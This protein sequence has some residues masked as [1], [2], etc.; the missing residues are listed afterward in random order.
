MAQKKS[1]ANAIA[2]D[3]AGNAYL[4]GTTKSGASFPSAQPLQN[5]V[6][7]NQ[8]SFYLKL[9]ATG[10]LQYAGLIGGNKND[11]GTGIALDTSGN[12]Y[13]TGYTDSA[14]D[15]PLAS[16]WQPVYGG[17]AWD[18][19]LVAITPAGDQLLYSSYFGGEKND[20]AQDI[21]VDSDGTVYL[22]GY[23][24]SPVD[25]PLMQAWQSIFGGSEDA[26]VAR[27]DNT[28]QLEYATYFGGKEKDAG[29]AIALDSYGGITI[30]G[31]T[32]S[33]D[34]LP[35]R[36]PLQTK[37]AGGVD[38]FI[39]RFDNTGNLVFSSYLGGNKDDQGEDIALDQL[40]DAYLVGGSKSPDKLPLMNPLQSVTGGGKDA[41]IARIFINS[42]PQIISQ[43]ITEAVDE[44]PYQYSVVAEDT[45]GDPLTYALLIAPAGM[46][47]DPDT[48][49]IDWPL[50]LLGDYPIQVRV[51]DDMGAYVDQNYVLTVIP[52]NQPPQIL[53]QPI[54]NAIVD[55]PY[56][57]A[58]NAVDPDADAIQYQL[59]Q[60]PL[61]MHIDPLSGLIQW[62]PIAAGDYP[63]ELQVSDSNATFTLQ[64]YNVTVSF[65]PDNLPPLLESLADQTVPV[66]TEVSIQ[67]IASDPENQ[68]LT[69]SVTPL[70]LPEGAN[71]D[72]RTGVFTFAPNA[73]QVGTHLFTFSV[74]DGRHHVVQ[75]LTLT[76][77]ALDA[78]APTRFIGR[79]VDS[80]ALDRG[81]DIPIVGATVSF[82]G[83]G[84]STT[85]DAN[86]DF[87]LTGLP[88]G[89][90]IFSIDS[91]TA[92]PAPGGA[93][94]ASYHIEKSYIDHV[95]NIVER[96]F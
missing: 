64:N 6:T 68:P 81:L 88:E 1:T 45:D 11:L 29:L 62:Q 44:V 21:A 31:R 8:D 34:T 85:S 3:D 12:V 10:A 54:I 35:L 43:A 90:Y 50:P 70:P 49:I 84:I 30:T 74:S 52:N 82:L 19:F 57:Y 15:F 87:I 60:A 69:F 94:Y 83:T 61:G 16:A 80:T 7:G 36:K 63:V 65:D 51:S 14:N 55:Q 33:K 48:G 53:S 42:A 92:D 47:I 39:A 67:L 66:G 38:A 75:T 86:G 89:L 56:Q 4:A 9:N 93:S 26:F 95:D 79:V 72:T 91:T 22:T 18:A 5:S 2:V 59:N 25:F 58:V 76:V 28:G 23:T 17:G 27:F 24:T 20:L 46:T 37:L 96:P 41:Y 73:D 77:P 13:V 71:L 78:A 32:G 40:A